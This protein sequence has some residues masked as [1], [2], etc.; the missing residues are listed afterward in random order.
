MPQDV[1]LNQMLQQEK[2]LLIVLD[3]CRYDA[4]HKL[5]NDRQFN[6]RGKHAHV[7]RVDSEVPNTHTWART[8]WDGEYDAT[9]I[10]PIPFISNQEV[11]GPTGGG[12]Y[13]GAEHFDKVVDVWRTDWNE[14]YDCVMPEDIVKHT[15]ANRDDDK[16]IAHFGHPHMPHL[17]STAFDQ[18][19]YVGENLAQMGPQIPPKELE[20]SYCGTLEVVWDDGV[21]PL[22]H[23]FKDR[24][25]C[26]TADHGEALGEGG[27]YGHNTMTPEVNHVPWIEV[28]ADE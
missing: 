23:D 1:R 10:S 6:V 18:D 14:E 15:M 20:E 5:V 3:A 13:Y 12:S 17:G 8:K 11:D 9:Y 2:F 4:L 26:I 22:L 19:E 25:I 21:L 28:P 24:T 16:I 27:R 7:E